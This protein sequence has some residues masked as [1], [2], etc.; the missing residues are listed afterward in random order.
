M[1]LLEGAQQSRRI[2][3]EGRQGQK[4]HGQKRAAGDRD[5]HRFLLM[6]EPVG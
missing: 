1:A 4:R 2:V 6:K 3:G 5:G